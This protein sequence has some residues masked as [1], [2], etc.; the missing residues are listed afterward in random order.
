[1][2]LKTITIFVL[3]F[4]LFTGCKNDTSPTVKP[5]GID[6][7][8]KIT[9]N[10]IVKKDDNFSLFYTQDGTTDFSKIKPLWVGVEGKENVQ[11]VVYTLPKKAVPTQLRLDFGLAKN[12]ENIFLKS[13]IIENNGKKRAIN[14][15]ELAGFFIADVKK[16]TFNASNGIIKAVIEDGVRQYPSLYP[17]EET[18]KAELEKLAQ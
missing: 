7:N 12:Q 15:A 17:Q 9:L 13:V 10:V 16:C 11:K 6:N 8:F 3:L 1:M 2:K 4:T 18:L 14:G 5:P